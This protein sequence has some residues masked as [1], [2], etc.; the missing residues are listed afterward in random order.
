MSWPPLAERAPRPG[1]PFASLLATEEPA[2]NGITEAPAD[3]VGDIVTGQSADCG[4][5]H[6]QRER[7]MAGGGD[8]PAVIT[9]VSLGTTGRIASSKASTNTTA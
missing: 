5:R 4:E 1:N 3:E 9:A 2:G 7:Q 6:D 8:Y